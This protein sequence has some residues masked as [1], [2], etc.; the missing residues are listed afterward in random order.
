[1]GSRRRGSKGRE[2]LVLTLEQRQVWFCDN[3]P[4]AVSWK[5]QGRGREHMFVFSSTHHQDLRS[6]TS[7]KCGHYLLDTGEP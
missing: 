3:R 6:S 4:E 2:M 7:G 5:A 1:M